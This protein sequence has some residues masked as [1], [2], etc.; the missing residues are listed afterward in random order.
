MA[1]VWSGF[2]VSAA[3]GTTYTTTTVALIQ[4]KS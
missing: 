2:H 3:A 1:G 4:K